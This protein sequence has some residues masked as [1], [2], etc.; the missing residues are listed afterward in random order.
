MTMLRVRSDISADTVR[1]LRLSFALFSAMGCLLSA[2]AR[3]AANEPLSAPERKAVTTVQVPPP[4]QAPARTPFSGEIVYRLTLLPR[5]NA[6][7][8]RDLGELHYFI[9][10]THWKHVDAKGVT[11]A[12]YDPDTHLVHYFP[13][14][15][16]VD[17]TLPDGD[18]TFESLPEVKVVLGRACKAIV[19]KTSKDTTTTFYDP[20]LFVDPR[21][22]ANHHWGHWA[23]TLAMTGGALSLW[24]KRESDVGDMIFEA[25]SIQPRTFPPSFWSLADAERATVSGG[26]P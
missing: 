8:D 4:A 25:Q 19:S 24:S 21:P 20:A 14:G 17:A 22:F 1:R 9:S 13:Q 2:C 10:G 18:V 6:S 16:V 3:P 12:L 5:D 7:A 11:L 15:K 23:E 26:A